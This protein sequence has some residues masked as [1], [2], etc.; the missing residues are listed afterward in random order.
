MLQKTNRHLGQEQLFSIKKTAA[1][2]F[3]LRLIRGTHHDK[4]EGKIC[5]ELIPEI[6]CGKKKKLK[7]EN[8]EKILRKKLPMQIL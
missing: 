7:F 6:E 2:S 4:P 5:E 1:L 3:C 8:W